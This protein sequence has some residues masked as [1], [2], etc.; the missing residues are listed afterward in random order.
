[1]TSRHPPSETAGLASLSID[2]DDHWTYLKSRGSAWQ[3]MPSFLDRAVPRALEFLS[4]H[5][6]RATFFVVGRDAAQPHHRTVLRR[7]VDA[8]H[9]IGNHSYHHDLRFDLGDAAAVEDDL[10]CAEAAIE[11]LGAPRPIGFRAPGHC[12]SPTVLDVLARRG[13]VYDASPWPTYVL[14][15]VRRLYLRG[16]ALTPAERV[17]RRQ[18][19]RGDRAL[20]W[21]NRPHAVGSPPL[22]IIPVTTV[23]F[24]RLPFHVTYLNALHAR[25]EPLARRYFE[26]A[27]AL[28]RHTNTPPSVLLHLTDFLG[29]DDPIDLSFLPGM[30]QPHQRKLALLDHVVRTLQRQFRVG[31]LIDHA[32]HWAASGFA[33]PQGTGPDRA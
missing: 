10:Q 19:G 18:Q 26:W 22:V 5:E 11:A 13:Y 1:M 15:L 17:R 25:S 31:P 29:S 16:A 8:A 32:R 20:R 7:I 30:R 2:L 3:S 12:V 6:L 9:E 24:V 27:L 4:R 21:S 23:P 33:S 14:P 28:C